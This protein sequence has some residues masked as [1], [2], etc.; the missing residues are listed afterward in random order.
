MSNEINGT[1]EKDVDLQRI[2]EFIFMNIENFYKIEL[3]DREKML[4]HV[5]YGMLDMALETEKEYVESDALETLDVLECSWDQVMGEEYEYEDVAN[6][7]IEN[8][9]SL[10]A[11]ARAENEVAD[12]YRGLE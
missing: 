9:D 6:W 10:F 4:M 3:T 12:K 1:I 8:V 2:T 5:Y 7:A 11:I